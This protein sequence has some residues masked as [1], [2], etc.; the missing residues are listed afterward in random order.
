[1]NDGLLPLLGC[2]VDSFREKAR[3]SYG[4]D[5]RAPI[6][7]GTDELISIHLQDTRIV[8]NPGFLLGVCHGS[9]LGFA[10]L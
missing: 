7:R 2:I 8:F 1:M 3:C 5:H 6:E 9:L 10:A 4:D